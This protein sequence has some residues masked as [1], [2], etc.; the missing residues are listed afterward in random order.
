MIP[1]KP[2]SRGWAVFRAFG[3]LPCFLILTVIFWE[4]A[5]GAGL[6][7]SW[8]TGHGWSILGWC[9]RVI[10]IA[11]ASVT[12]V[13]SVIVFAAWIVHLCRVIKGHMTSRP[14]HALQP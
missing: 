12:A 3:I 10:G 1:S 7:G 2:E 6:L 14:N 5:V 11:I 4:L 8:A 9:F 13:A